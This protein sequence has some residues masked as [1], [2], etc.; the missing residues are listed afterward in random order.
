MMTILTKNQPFPDP[1]PKG[2]LLL[3]DKPLGWTSFSV[4]NKIRYALSHRLGIKKYKTG[5]AG[6]L[7]PLA[8]GLLIICVGEYTKKIEEFQAMPK[9]YTGVITFGAT[10]PSFDLEKAVDATYPVEH[11]TD[12]LLQRVKQQFTGDILQIPPV[13]SA[14]KVDGRRLY[15]N[16]RTGEEVE[17]PERPVRIESFEIGPLRPSPSTLHL[18]P[19][20][21]N[22]KGV[23]IM[24]HPDYA[25]GLQ[26]DFRVV[27]SKGTYIRS[28]VHDLGRAAGSGAY[29]SSLR[30]TGTGGFSVEDAWDLDALV[31]WIQK[32]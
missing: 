22:K 19:S 25:E 28:L 27:C 21:F 3:V 9:E 1:F 2:A 12:A 24:L 18:P 11:L 6:T 5:H 8:T 16:A 15:K 29:L 32:N 13:F 4:V 14:V 26:A 17:L 20:T 7:D 23:S 31:H 30:R 10:T